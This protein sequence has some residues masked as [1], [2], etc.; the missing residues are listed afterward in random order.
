[1]SGIPTP[2]VVVLVMVG[3]FIIVGVILWVADLMAGPCGCGSLDHE[4]FL[5]AAT[6]R[7]PIDAPAADGRDMDPHWGEEPDEPGPLVDSSGHD[8]TPGADLDLKGGWL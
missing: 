1:M 2:A 3:A 8:R 4:A 5:I 7:D 6:G